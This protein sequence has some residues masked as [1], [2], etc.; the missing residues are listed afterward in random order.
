MALL[1]L[2][3]ICMWLVVLPAKTETARCPRRRRRYRRLIAVPLPLAWPALL[4]ARL[5]G[6]V[7]RG[8]VWPGGEGENFIL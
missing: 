2:A 1:K 4:L 6:I 7:L 8:A 3:F 5:A